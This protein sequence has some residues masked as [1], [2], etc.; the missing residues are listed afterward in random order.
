MRRGVHYDDRLND[1]SRVPIPED[2]DVLRLLGGD[3]QLVVDVIAA[4]ELPPVPPRVAIRVA[5]NG[6][7][8]VFERDGSRV[9]CLAPGSVVRNA[10]IVQHTRLFGVIAQRDDRHARYAAAQRLTGEQSP[11]RALFER[12]VSAGRSVSREDFHAFAWFA[13]VLGR[14]LFDFYSQSIAAS[15]MRALNLRKRRHATGRAA[16]I[17][18]G[19]E[20]YFFRLGNLAITVALSG[21]RMIEDN[22]IRAED[23]YERLV[24]GLLRLGTVGAAVRSSWVAAKLG[25][26]ILQT[27]K[28]RYQSAQTPVD[29]VYAAGPLLAIAARHKN[30]RAEITKALRGRLANLAPAHA[31]FATD[32]KER[33]SCIA[34]QIRPKE[35]TDY[36]LLRLLGIVQYQK[37]TE[38]LPSDSPLR[39]NQFDR[40]PADL[41]CA[42][43][44][45]SVEPINTEDAYWQYLRLAPLVALQEPESFCLPQ[46]L[47]TALARKWTT[48]DS[49]R[50]ARGQTNCSDPVRAAHK[51]GR[52]EPCP[53][54][55]KK[56]YKLCHGKG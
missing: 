8:G 39:T 11:A 34:D 6:S 44:A 52:N 35:E 50:L 54:G 4:E 31:A 18:A 3:P 25:N 36:S 53:C 51:L 28:E 49:V 47:L 19:Y 30:L 33:V 20:S 5:E 55:S 13:P 56:K 1:P 7:Y 2:A 41:A 22:Q 45:D 27:V 46:E 48:E 26:A 24:A 37:L 42:V 15:W 9:T 14:P 17:L 43:L 29:L 40:M 12:V 16:P 38:Q 32:F 23:A 10:H 21:R